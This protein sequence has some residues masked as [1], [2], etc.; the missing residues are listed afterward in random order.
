[1]GDG[2][3]V[4]W[5]CDRTDKPTGSRDQHAGSLATPCSRGVGGSGGLLCQSLH[6]QAH[7]DHGDTVGAC[8][9]TTGTSTTGT[10]TTGTTD[11]I[12]TTTGDTTTTGDGGHQQKVCVLRHKHN[13][14]N[15]HRVWDV[16]DLH[17]G[18]KVVKDKICIS[19]RR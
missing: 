13:N 12:G 8:E 1:M 17:L 14:K 16:E 6:C 10:S 3:A 15:Y 4:E 11:T 18:D 19:E 5:C 2:L 9:E 7:L